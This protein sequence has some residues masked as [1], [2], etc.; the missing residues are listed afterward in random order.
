[1]ADFV[2]V[3]KTAEIKPDAHQA[4]SEKQGDARQGN[5]AAST[6]P[7]FPQESPFDRHAPIP[8]RHVKGS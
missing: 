6:K 8:L 5:G 1:M 2:K 3:A 4:L 7:D